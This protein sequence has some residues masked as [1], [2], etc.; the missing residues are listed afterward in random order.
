MV[1]AWMLLW[2]TTIGTPPRCGD[3]PDPTALDH[4]VV[5]HVHAASLKPVDKQLAAGSHYASPRDVPFVCALTVLDISLGGQR[6]FFGGC[7]PP[8]GAMAQRTVVPKAFV[9]PVPDSVSDEL[10]AALPNPGVS[11]WLALTFRAKLAHGENV[12]VLGEPGSRAGW[13]FKSPDSW[14]RDVWWRRDA[15]KIA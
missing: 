13:Q 14:A 7:G 4:E 5:V 12:L 6:V 3:F 2:C 11:A 10:A 8:F 1:L 9:F 15:I